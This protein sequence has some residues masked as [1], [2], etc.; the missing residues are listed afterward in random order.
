MIVGVPDHTQ[1]ADTAVGWLNLAWTTAI[2]ELIQFQEFEYQFEDIEKEHGKEVAE[3]EIE[4]YWTSVNF[5]LNNAVSLFQQSIEPF[6]KTRIAEVSPFL[7]IASDSQS[8]PKLDGNGDIDFSN[9]RT[10]DAVNL[11]RT[12]TAVSPHGLPP[13]FPFSFDRIR[14]VRNKIVHL[15]AGQWR[16][17]VKTVLLDILAG[18]RMLYP[19]AS[20]L[21]FRKQYFASESLLVDLYYVKDS[22]HTQIM[23]EIRA[24]IAEFEP[25][26][27]KQYFGYD[28]RKRAMLCPHC[29]GLRSEWDDDTPEFVQRQ[30]DGSLRCVVCATSY[31]SEEYAE[32]MEQCGK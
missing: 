28:A 1:L 19:D 5:T 11:V 2:D 15:H 3:K 7:L 13:D 8:W 30:K 4:R 17:E 31:S 26:Y 12:V 29:M 18:Y 32:E 6:L 20:W 22:S 27:L 23:R 24:C 16:V 21:G 25:R 14:R 10:I 9:F